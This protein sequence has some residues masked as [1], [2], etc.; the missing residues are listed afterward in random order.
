MSLCSHLSHTF[1]LCRP[2][3]APAVVSH[4]LNMRIILRLITAL[5]NLTGQNLM[6]SARPYL[7]FALGVGSSLKD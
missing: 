6:T 4:I 5:L 3:L 7:H 2:I 1:T